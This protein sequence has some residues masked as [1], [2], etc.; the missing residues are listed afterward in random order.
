MA[1]RSRTHKDVANVAA[2]AAVLASVVMCV[3]VAI[4]TGSIGLGILPRLLPV[5][6]VMAIEG[7][8]AAWLLARKSA[9]THS[10]SSGA[11]IRNPFSLTA[12]LTFGAVYALVLLLVQGARIYFGARGIYLA[13]ALA[14]IADVDAVSIAC[15]RL[16]TVE[17]T[18]RT[19][20]AAAT[21]AVVT[22]TLVKLAIALVAGAG[23]FKVYVAVALAIM[24][25]VGAA[26]GI[27]IFLRF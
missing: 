9:V 12:A 26:V 20:A 1:T 15:A 3:R 19:P 25:A 18:W 7:T 4:L 5:V 24:A 13:A 14:A 16:G 8:V 22:N 10:G 21:V 17:A 27:F 2:A 6:G 23:S 11:E